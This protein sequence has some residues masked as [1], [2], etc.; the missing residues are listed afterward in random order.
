M[1]GWS[2]LLKKYS[3][4]K[5]IKLN[6]TFSLCD[7]LRTHNKTEIPNALSFDHSPIFCSFVNDDTFAR[8]S[9]VWKLNNS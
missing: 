9:G 2:P 1:R 7:I 6:K 8:G 5:I 4:S 3:L